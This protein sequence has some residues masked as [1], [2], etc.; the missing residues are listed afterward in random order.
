[1]HSSGTDSAARLAEGGACA[2]CSALLPNGTRGVRAARSESLEQPKLRN[3]QPQSSRTQALTVPYIIRVTRKDTA[4]YVGSGCICKYFVRNRSGRRKA[5]LREVGSK[6]LVAE[7]TGIACSLRA[8]N[9][10]HTDAG[11]LL[12][13]SPRLCS[14]ER[15]RCPAVQIWHTAAAT[16]QS[17]KASVNASCRTDLDAAAAV[18][19]SNV[20]LLLMLKPTSPLVL[21]VLLVA[22]TVDR[23]LHAPKFA[24]RARPVEQATSSVGLFRQHKDASGRRQQH[25]GSLGCKP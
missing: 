21:R 22:D 19:Q 24:C 6:D 1:M 13:V 5:H 2:C 25:Q 11:I 18:Q 14:D 16:Q 17:Q 15:C 12:S 23:D 20:W 9:T 10:A 7:R 3:Q 8:G 4:R